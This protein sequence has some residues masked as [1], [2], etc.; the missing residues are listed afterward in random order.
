[1]WNLSFGFISSSF[2]LSAFFSQFHWNL[3]SSYNHPQDTCWHPT[4]GKSLGQPITGRHG[5]GSN[6]LP[7]G[8]RRRLFPDGPE[9][10]GSSSIGGFP[11]WN[12][13]DSRGLKTSCSLSEGVVCGNILPGHLADPVDGWMKVFSEGL[14]WVWAG[15][16]S[17][18]LW[19]GLTCQRLCIWIVWNCSYCS[20]MK[21]RYCRSDG[22]GLKLVV[23]LLIHI[24]N[25]KFWYITM[26]WMIL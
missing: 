18:R 14:M 15:D 19:T 2:L 3:S 23:L 5:C 22:P 8:A 26:P 12:V 7:H 4:A 13:M 9:P 16:R 20:H 11:P 24:K 25:H 6:V 17:L 10:L 1:M 21:L